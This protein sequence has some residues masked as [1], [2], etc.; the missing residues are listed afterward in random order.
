MRYQLFAILLWL[1]PSAIEA[2]AILPL[3]VHN[4]SSCTY[5][6]WLYILHLDIP[7]LA[8][9]TTSGSSNTMRPWICG[10]CEMEIH[11]WGHWIEF[12][13]PIQVVNTHGQLEIYPPPVFKYRWYP[14]SRGTWSYVSCAKCHF[15]D[16]IRRWHV[17]M[18]DLQEE[19][20][21]GH[22]ELNTFLRRMKDFQIEFRLLLFQHCSVLN[23]LSP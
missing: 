7:P 8:V 23:V 17:R 4:T 6:L 20:E 15:I 19:F 3:A 2:L 1:Q 5:Y 13:Q 10:D 16:E 18:A 21:D 9:H 22:I 11:G 14:T 12:E